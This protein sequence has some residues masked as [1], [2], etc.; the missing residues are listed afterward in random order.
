M[1]VYPYALP[2]MPQSMGDMSANALLY[3]MLQQQLLATQALIDQHEVETK[4]IQNELYDFSKG[5]FYEIINLRSREKEE[6]NEEK[7]RG[8]L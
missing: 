3:K 8:Q 5:S 2:V 1:P 4:K 7:S 6:I